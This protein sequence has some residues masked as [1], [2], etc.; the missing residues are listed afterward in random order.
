MDRLKDILQKEN[1]RNILILCL[2]S[3]FVCLPLLSNKINIMYDDGVQHIA[4]LIGTYQSIEEGQTFPVIMSK[5]CNNFGYSWNLF[6][7]PLTAYIPLI[8]KLMGLSFIGCTKLFMF[9][10]VFLSGITM[11]FFTREVTKNNKI[12]LIA[13]IFYIFAPYRLTDMYARNALAELTSFIF[14]PMIFERIIWNIKTKTKKRIFTYIGHNRSNFNTYSNYNV[15]S[16]YLFYIYAYTNKKVKK[17]KSDKKID[18]IISIYPINYKFF[19]CS[20]IRTQ[21]SS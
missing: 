2:A 18:N 4:R 7:S 16:N 14:I 9:F 17:Q 6:Y 13:G 12:A 5:F 1:V 20:F 15:Y 3:I 11:Y 10:V 8:F 21:T 19:L